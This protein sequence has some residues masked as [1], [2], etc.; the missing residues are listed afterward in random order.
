MRN[1]CIESN[2]TLSTE[3][4]DKNGD[5]SK[6]LD[7]EIEQTGDKR[8]AR[9]TTQNE[10]RISTSS[11]DEFFNENSNSTSSGFS[12]CAIV[13]TNQISKETNVHSYAQGNGD[14]VLSKLNEI[15][16]RVSG[17]EKNV[18]KLD[19]RVRMMSSNMDG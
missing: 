10:K 1:L 11:R 7:E 2:E 19:V 8:R 13:S 9:K 12:D 4:S 3:Q 18:A 17:V 6:N 15:L 16:E 14:T 5:S